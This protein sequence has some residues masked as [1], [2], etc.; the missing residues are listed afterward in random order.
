MTLYTNKK[1]IRDKLWIHY[2]TIERMIEKK[3][4]FE[5]KDMKNRKIY[6]IKK[7]MIKYLLENI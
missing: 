6:I 5:L 2:K 1:Q 3:D 7:D 4:I